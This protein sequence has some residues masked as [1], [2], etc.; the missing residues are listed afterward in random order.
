MRRTTVVSGLV[1]GLVAAGLALGGCSAG[2]ASGSAG[3]SASADVGAA[4]APASAPMAAPAASSGAAAEGS[5]AG[6]TAARTALHPQAL[7]VTV[8]RTVRVRDV[9]KAVAGASALAQRLGGHV[10]GEDGRDD[11]EDRA[12][13]REQVVL[14]VPPARVDALVSGVEGYGD[15]LVRTRK[16]LDVTQQVQDVDARLANARA[17]VARVRQFYARAKDVKDVVLMEGELSRRVAD[18]ESLEAQHATLSD[19]TTLATVTVTFVG[20]SAVV[21]VHRTGFTAGLHSGADAFAASVTVVLT[22]LGAVLPFVPLA[23][24]VG[25]LGWWLVRSARRRSRMAT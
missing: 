3:S 17:S 18:L 16:D 25:M 20:R 2:G 6:G 5:S 11:P 15:V 9:A 24:V 13:A 19:S 4:P 23:L 10:E 21:P 7:V 22:A 14:R 12:A 8:G 1:A